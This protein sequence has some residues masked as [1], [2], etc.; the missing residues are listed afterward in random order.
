MSYT[1]ILDNS[2]ELMTED[3]MYD[4]N[5]GLFGWSS[6]KF[7]KNLNGLFSGVR[8]NMPAGIGVILSSLISAAKIGYSTDLPLFPKLSAAVAAIPIP[9][10]RVIAATLLVAGVGLFTSMGYFRMFY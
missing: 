7:I 9:G 3:E 10:F 4:V 2:W 5:G 6:D 1:M 8:E